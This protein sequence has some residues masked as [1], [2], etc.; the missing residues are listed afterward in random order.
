MALFSAKAIVAAIIGSGGA[1]G[2][3]FG[4]HEIV[5]ISERAAQEDSQFKAKD[6]DNSRSGS[7]GAGTSEKIQ[8]S[9]AANN[10][11]VIISEEKAASGTSTWESESSPKGGW[12]VTKEDRPQDLEIEDGE[13]NDEDSEEVEEQEIS[14]KL[15]LLKGSEGTLDNVYQLKTYYEENKP[16]FD[17]TT[18]GEFPLSGLRSRIDKYVESFNQDIWFQADKLDTFT[19]GLEER[20]TPFKRVFKSE[21]YDRLIRKLQELKVPS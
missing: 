10:P 13:E 9:P 12:I 14:G 2:G 19:E 11:L 17:G 8:N 16:I 1:V 7:S 18:L 5:R 20:E 15:V 3:G 6:Q 4:L 21:V